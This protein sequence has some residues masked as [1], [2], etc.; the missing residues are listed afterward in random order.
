ME[1]ECAQ[2]EVGWEVPTAGSGRKLGGTF[3]QKLGEDRSRQGQEGTQSP[4][5]SMLPLVSRFYWPDQ[6]PGC[7]NFSPVPQL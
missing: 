5:L 2:R 1:A 7:F 3:P 4:G 6:N